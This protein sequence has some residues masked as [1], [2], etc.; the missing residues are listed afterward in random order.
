M[1]NRFSLRL[2]LQYILSEQQRGKARQPDACQRPLP[3]TRLPQI[4]E[5]P[6]SPYVHRGRVTNKKIVVH[7][8]PPRAWPFIL[9][10]GVPGQKLER[11]SGGARREKESVPR[12]P[13]EVGGAELPPHWRLLNQSERN[14]KKRSEVE[15]TCLQLQLEGQ[16]A[17]APSSW[18]PAR[19]SVKLLALPPPKA[20]ACRCLPQP[21]REALLCLPT[22]TGHGCSPLPQF[23]S[24]SQNFMELRQRERKTQNTYSTG[25]RMRKIRVNGMF[26]ICQALCQKKKNAS[27][28][29]HLALTAQTLSSP[30]GR[31]RGWRSDDEVH[32]L[33]EAGSGDE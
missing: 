18:K 20:G 1:E 2:P 8:L 9:Q 3:P 7:P 24:I 29:F 6:R 14:E 27:H 19:S 22:A 10:P 21:L 11:S 15:N 17:F 16:G 25:R 4:V 30:F 12:C 31:W 23:P 13:A 26:L 5:G 33:G 32:T 28:I